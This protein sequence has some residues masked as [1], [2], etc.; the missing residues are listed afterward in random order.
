MDIQEVISLNPTLQ[1]S[2]LLPDAFAEY[3][4]HVGNTPGGRSLKHDR[5][6]QQ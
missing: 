3:I 1:D 5:Q 4:Y 2:V 6:S